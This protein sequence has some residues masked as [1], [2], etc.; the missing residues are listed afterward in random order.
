METSFWKAYLL[1]NIV[2]YGRYFLF[3]GLAYL[4]FYVLN[5]NKWIE[6]KIQKKYPESKQ[7]KREIKDSLLSIFI[8]SLLF[9]VISS[10]TKAG[11]TKLYFRISDMGWL[12]FCFSVPLVIF[13]H[14]TWFYWTHRLM[15]IPQI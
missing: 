14:D 6:N 8:F 5:K 15:H 7:I 10:A 2:F 13:W 3:A 9:I 1:H 12:Y 11:Y 4:L